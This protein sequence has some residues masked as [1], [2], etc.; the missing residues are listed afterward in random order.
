MTQKYELKT[1]QTIDTINRLLDAGIKKISVLI[2]HSDRFFSKEAR[3][4]PYMGL[5]DAG[6]EYAV[7]FGAAIRAN[8]LPKLTSSFI[9]RCV[10]TAYLI[11]KGFTKK[12]HRNLD[13]NCMNDMLSPFYVKDVEKALPCIKE[14]GNDLFLRNWFDNYFDESIM[15]NPKKTSDLLS[16]FMVEQIKNLKENQMAICV[17]HDWNIYPLKEFKLGLKHETTGDVGYLDGLVFFE[18][19]NHYYITNYQTNPV[20]L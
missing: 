4:E 17:S 15:E 14:Q 19:E 1:K 12:N 3:R 6:K 20:L 16:E 18:K 10:E 8:P 13:H 5:T 11:D 2:R 7:N 9:G